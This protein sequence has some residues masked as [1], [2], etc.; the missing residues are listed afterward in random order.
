MQESKSICALSPLAV[1]VANPPLHVRGTNAPKKLPGDPVA[2]AYSRHT[3]HVQADSSASP[4]AFHEGSPLCADSWKIFLL[5]K[6]FYWEKF[7]WKKF[8]LEKEFFVGKRIRGFV[9]SSQPVMSLLSSQPQLGAPSGELPICSLPILG[10]PI[11]SPPTD[12]HTHVHI[13]TRLALL[14][15]IKFTVEASYFEIYNEKVPSPH[16][17]GHDD[18]ICVSC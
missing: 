7:Y 14:Q 9:P 16:P 3:T 13:S 2:R 15:G 12:R 17:V 4:S 8:L 5:E 11:S 1:G 10:Q 18:S 6:N